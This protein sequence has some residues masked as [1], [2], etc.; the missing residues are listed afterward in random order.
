M[1]TVEIVNIIHVGINQPK[2]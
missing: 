1:C 2:M